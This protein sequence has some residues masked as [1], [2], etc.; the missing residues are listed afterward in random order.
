MRPVDVRCSFFLV[1]KKNEWDGD[2]FET[3]MEGDWLRTGEDQNGL[4]SFFFSASRMQVECSCNGGDD[5]NGKGKT[6]KGRQNL[7]ASIVVGGRIYMT[8]CMYTYSSIHKRR[9]ENPN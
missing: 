9:C 7:S 3:E 4:C 5:Q 2:G 8:I 6:L 1:R